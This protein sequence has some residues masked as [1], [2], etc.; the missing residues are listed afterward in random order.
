MEENY[1]FVG[2]RRSVQKQIGNAV[3]SILGKAIVEHLM[4][5]I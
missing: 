4:S 5:N 3:P 1:H 2:S